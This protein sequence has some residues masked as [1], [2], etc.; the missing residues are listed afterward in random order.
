MLKPGFLVLENGRVFPGVLVGPHREVIGEVVFNTSMTGYQEILTDPSYAGQLVALTYPLIGNYG[1]NREDMES[2]AVGAA[3]LITSELCLHPSNWRAEKSLA[4]FLAEHGVPALAGVDTRALTLCLREAG[5]MRGGITSKDPEGFLERVRSHP[6]PSSEELVGRVTACQRYTLG[7]GQIHAVVVD[8]GAKRGILRALVSRGLRLTVVPAATSAEEILE[9][10]PD[11]IVLS[12]G[13]GDP[14]ELVGAIKT[15][16]LLA[17]RAPILGICLGH[18]LLALALGARTYKLKFGHRGANHPVREL[19]TGRVHITSQ[20]HGYAV[21][22]AG[23]PSQLAISHVSLH[24][25][26]VEG[27][28]SQSFPALSVQFHPEAGPGPKDTG[29]I[30]DEFLELIAGRKGGTLCA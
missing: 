14:A 19:A 4:A 27:L 16:R 10:K 18:Q 21:S 11:G 2:G 15:V 23:L 17:G 30:F 1:T 6:L 3:A 22:A 28:R 20:N 26:T 12:N 9:L 7:T 25:G 29:G 5:T 13:P 8:F 24:D